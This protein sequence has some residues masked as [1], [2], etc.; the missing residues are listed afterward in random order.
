MQKILFYHGGPGLNGNPER[1]L[2]ASMYKTANLDLQVWDE[3]SLLRGTLKEL[4]TRTHFE[5]LL[6]SAEDFLLQH[7][8]GTPLHLFGSS[9]GAQ[10]V[11]W[12]QQNHSD[13]VASIILSAPCFDIYK[14]DH[15]IFTFIAQD[16][17][18]NNDDS[19]FEKMQQVIERLSGSFDDNAIKGWELALANPGFLNYYWTNTEAQAKYLAN[20]IAPEYGF[21]IENFFAVRKSMTDIHIIP[22]STK[23]I[24]VYGAR[25]KIVIIPEEMDFIKEKFPRHVI[26]R[27]EHSSHYPHI[28]EAQRVADIIAA[29][30]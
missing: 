20:F 28:E 9:W 25:D 8:D 27:L 23:T 1:N 26:Y 15:N 3:P 4:N 2:L 6:H 16:Y 18:G 5:Q 13:K 17:K 14:A 21:D 22:T 7:Y 10:V 29:E 24:I 30:V 19:N 12:L 11:A